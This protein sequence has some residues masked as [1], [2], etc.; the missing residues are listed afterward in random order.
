[1]RLAGFAIYRFIQLPGEVNA[2]KADFTLLIRTV[3]VCEEILVL[4]CETVREAE[5]LKAVGI[6]D[7]PELH[8]G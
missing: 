7:G 2:D 6:A 4:R 8:L 3:G 1:L 5:N